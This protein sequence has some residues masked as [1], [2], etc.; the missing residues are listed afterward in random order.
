VRSTIALFASSRRDGN[1]GTVIDRIAAA[2]AIEVVDLSQI[3][4]S[5]YDYEHQ[6]RAD[7]FEPLMDRILGYEQI[8]FAAP[9]YWYS[10]PPP[11]KVF[12]DRFSDFLDVPELRPKGRRLRGKRGYVVATSGTVEISPAFLYV[13]KETFEYLGMQYRGALHLNCDGGYTP[14][15]FEREIDDF[16]SL[17]RDSD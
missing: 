15:K 13:F 5:A 3:R 11:M 16:V 2:L 1:T 17:V 12:L 10:A 8:I 4:M 6:N 14:G 7:E 9:V